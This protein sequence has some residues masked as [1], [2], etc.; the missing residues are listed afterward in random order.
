MESSAQIPAD[1]ALMPDGIGDSKVRPAEVT[2]ATGNGRGKLRLLTR[3]NLDGR[4]AAAKQFDAIAQG[5]ADD[6][7]GSEKLSTIQL[8]L[9]ECF[10]GCAIIINAINTKLLT[11]GAIDVTE[12]SQAASTLVRLA[13][14]LGLHRRKPDP[15][16][17][18]EHITKAE[19]DAEAE[20]G[21][22]S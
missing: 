15:Y 4:T 11:G 21:A 3:Q 22:V 16:D 7:K 19:A 14:R 17:L 20:T 13:S 5:I 9:I 10:A 1:V 2:M 8:H 18:T 12:H 6:L